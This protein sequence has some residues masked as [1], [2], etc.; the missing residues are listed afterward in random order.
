MEAKIT[1]Q[2]VLELIAEQSRVFNQQLQAQSQ[3]LHAQSQQL[4]AQSQQLQSQSQQFLDSLKQSEKVS[5]KEHKKLRA[6]IGKL[7]GTWGRFVVEMVK[8]KLVKMFNK[9]GIKIKTCLQHVIGLY[10]DKEYY[11]IDLL[12]INSQFAVV[13]EIK[14]SLTVEDV[15]EHIERL[16]KLKRVPPERVDLRGVTIYGAVAGMLID[17]DAD[18]YAYRQG[19]FVLKQSGKMVKIVNDDK[20]EPNTW[21]TEY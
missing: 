18:K 11:E 19:L 12:L 15:K 3:Q 21:K 8:P 20:F 9:R 7:T 2:D 14:S 17:G 13:V 10:E 5:E 1:Y 16:E 4:Q 6:D